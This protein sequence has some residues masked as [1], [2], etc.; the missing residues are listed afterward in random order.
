ME[1]VVSHV[2]FSRAPLKLDLK[3]NYQVLP[4]FLTKS[5]YYARAGG[6]HLSQLC[7]ELT[8]F[9]HVA[10]WRRPGW[11]C[12][13]RPAVGG[14]GGGRLAPP[15]EGGEVC[16]GLPGAPE[17]E[18]GRTS[19]SG[20]GWTRSGPAGSG[21]TPSPGSRPAGSF[22]RCPWW[23]P[24][25]LTEALSSRCQREGLKTSRYIKTDGKRSVCQSVTHYYVQEFNNLFKL[26]KALSL[27]NFHKLHIPLSNLSSCNHVNTILLPGWL[28]SGSQIFPPR[29]PQTE[30][31]LKRDYESSWTV[32]EGESGWRIFSWRVSL[33]CHIP[34]GTSSLH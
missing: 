6:E 13:R 9:G 1:T 34:P 12:P 10:A 22:S 21:R 8:Q 31:K 14:G 4:N 28:F 23:W 16:P 29:K 5:P 32:E 25:R 19:S 26:L 24:L 33:Q 20:P 27:K 2:V 18:A 15:L 11:R 7:S 30:V 3:E 17:G